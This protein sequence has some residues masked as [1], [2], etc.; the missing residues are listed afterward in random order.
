MVAECEEEMTIKDLARE[1][2][3]SVG[4]VSRVLNNHPNVSSRAREAILEYADKCG[5]QLNATA[6]NLRQQ[7]G[8]GILAIINGTSNELFARLLEQVQKKLNDTSYPLTVDYIDENDDPV[9]YAQR[10]IVE[11]KPQGILF[12]GGDTRMFLRSFGKISLPSLMLTADASSL[13]FPNLS[14]V[15]TDDTRA[16]DCAIEYLVNHGHKK[17]GIISGNLD[18]MG[19]SYLRFVGC[20]NA[21][22]R[23][24]I[25]LNEHV[26]QT[27][28]FSFTDG[29]ASM[30]RLIEKHQIS[31]VFAMSDVMAIG[32]MRAITDHGLRVPEDISVFGFDGLEI[33]D[34][35]IPK[36]TTIKQQVEELAA[37]GVE[38]LLDSIEHN[39]SARHEK[40]PFTLI[41]K[42]SVQSQ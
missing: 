9:L 18:R 22:A 15:T 10:Q 16:A 35:Y 28:R 5:F 7:H 6:K 33:G 20:Q 36:L 24:Q 27:A 13:G 4:T 1:T 21:L 41:E 2:G 8:I 17:I 19:P 12:F 30:E 3:Y 11:K 32:A 37:R 26:L 39:T 42:Q 23:H 14:S 40:I 25:E 38:I 31:A 34:Y 29:Y